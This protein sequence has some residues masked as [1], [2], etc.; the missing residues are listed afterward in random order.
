MDDSV[1][2]RLLK[3]LS[4][5]ASLLVTDREA[6]L[7][8]L[9]E[10]ISLHWRLN[11]STHPMTPLEMEQRLRM[12]IEDW[13]DE[14][15]RGPYVGPLYI[16]DY[17]SP[18]CLEMALELEPTV[19]V[20]RVQ[21]IIRQVRDSCR[22]RN[23]GD[24]LYRQFRS[25]IVQHPIVDLESNVHD[26]L[27]P[28]GIGLTDLYM[29]IPE[30]LKRNR[31]IYPCP[32]CGWPMTLNVS[33]V[34]CGS[35]W[36]AAVGGMFNWTPLGL[37]SNSSGEY[38]SGHTVSSTWMLRPA[39]WQFTLVPGLLELSIARRLGELGL[40]A[41]LWPDVDASDVRVYLKDRIINIDAK[42]WRSASRLATHLQSLAPKADDWIVI[43]DF[44]G[45]YL[46][47]LREQSSLQVFT[48]SECVRAVAKQC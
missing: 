47:Y 37:A 4:K 11:P 10:A 19:G 30:H 9:R 48:E 25:F 13:L 22:L 34:T 41:V 8:A 28:I 40:E 33:P 14:T 46:S 20:E 21:G 43:P 18:S 24:H 42:V 29:E 5:C 2:N 1:A 27:V 16:G 31:L 36:C 6:A 32:V 7:P 45:R 35:L 44:M 39:I 26:V 15:V 17:P 23:G 3:A 12:P 38:I